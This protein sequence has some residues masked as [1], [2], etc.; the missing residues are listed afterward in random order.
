MVNSGRA[1][2]AAGAHP[3]A[4]ANPNLGEVRIGRLEAAAM[5]D[6]HREHAGHRAG[7]RH[8]ARARSTDVR[9]H[10]DAVVDAPVPGVVPDWFVIPHYR[11]VDRGIQRRTGRSQRRGREGDHGMGDDGAHC[12]LPATASATYRSAPVGARGLEV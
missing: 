8:P 5:I 12:C 6:G 7:E 1:E 2:P 9:S 10:G 11:C 4:D 3:L